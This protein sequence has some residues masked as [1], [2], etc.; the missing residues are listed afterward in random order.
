MKKNLHNHFAN[1]AVF[2]AHIVALISLIVSQ[3]FGTIRPVSALS[4][5]GWGG[6]NDQTT[7][8]TTPL[9]V[10]RDIT[11]VQAVSNP[12]I[13]ARANDDYVEGWDWQAGS[14]VTIEISR[15]GENISHTATVGTA[16]WD[17]S[18]PY[19]EYDFAGEFDIQTGDLITVTSGTVTRA[20]TVTNLAF[21]NID[22]D[23][24][25]VTGIASAGARVEIW[26]CKNSDCNW[27]RHVTA[28]DTS[29]AW[30]VDF[31]NVGTEP[32]EQTT[33]D[34]SP[35]IW[36]DSGEYDVNGNGT[37]YGVAI[38]NPR[39]DAWFEDGVIDAYDWDIGTQLTL[40]IEDPGTG[41]SPDYSTTT[42]VAIAPQDPN[43]TLGKF[44]LNGA[45][46]I[47]PGMIITVSG[48][49]AT[50]QLVVS[51]LSVTSV[52]L[53]NDTISGST[54]PNQD[55]WMWYES[56][57]CRGFRAND[58]GVWT[59]DYSVEGADGE[60][61]ADV[62]PG[63]SGFIN[64]TDNDGDN[65]SL[66]WNVVDQRFTLLTVSKTGTGSGTVISGPT[67]ITC[68][69]DCSESYIYNTSVTLTATPDT[70]STFTGWS[71]ACTGTGSCVV[72]I[73]AVKSVTAAFAIDSYTLTASKD[74]TGSGTVTSSPAGIICG[75]DCS[76][77]YIYDTSV[78]LT[79]TPDTGSAFTGWSGVCT[80]TGAC[81]IAMTAAK[82]VTATFAIDTYA[83]TASKD[84]TGSGT[85]TSSPVGITCGADCSENY[86][87]NTSVTLTATPAAGSTFTGWSGA[88]TGTGAC[89]VSMTA[90]K[91][92]TA[93][94]TINTYALTIS[95]DGT[96]NGMVTSSPAG[97]I[98]GADCSESYIYNTSV[99]LTATP[100]TGSTFTGWSGACTG[101]G[102]CVITMAA[103][104]SVT[105]TFTINTY[106]LTVSKTGAGSG[107]VT[108]GPAGITCGADCSENYV[109][110]T[111]VT[112]T[113]TPATGSA[114]TGWSGACTGTGA[115]VVSMTA[116][117]SVTATFAIT[118]SLTVGK[119]GDGSG[120][121]TSSPAGITCGTDCSE[122]Y[123]YNTS[124]TLTA[125]P[126]TGSTF[127]GWGGACTG[128]GACVVTMTAAKSVTATFTKTYLLTASKAGT[129]SGTVTSSPAGIAC[130]TDCSQ[131]YNYNTPV[132]LTA[133][134]ATGSTFTG[135]SGACTGTGSCV[136]TMTT[137]KSVTAAF[138]LKTYIL[139]VSKAGI[140]S[141]TVT[142]SPVGITC[143]TDCSQSYNYNIKVTLTATPATG[144][145][146]SGWS[147]ACTGTGACVVTMTAAKSVIATYTKT[148]LLTV[149]KAGTGGGTVTSTPI[150][151][152]CGTDCSQNYNYNTTVTL[153]AKPAT[154]STFSGWS[155]AC[156]GTGSCVV[157][158]MA[159]K[160][161]TATFT[162]KTYAL[163]VTKAGSGTVTSSPVGITCGVDCSQNYNYNTKVTLTARPA[164]GFR[165][166]GWS[167]ACT[168]TGTCVVTMTAAK[169]AKAT[170]T[171]P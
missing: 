146:F 86:A 111:S 64:A 164:T 162:I 93:T 74:G 69:A 42:T 155:G 30:T 56:S 88:C 81:I 105:A 72:P 35:G 27:S 78:T 150:G 9:I 103:V 102:S 26:V 92:V 34:I 80:G 145:A 119:A 171:S 116:A 23:T 100:D 107:T 60:P 85:V 58:S 126:A 141:G 156:T 98:C 89:V 121:V 73:T 24:D 134:P 53:V 14:T 22:L 94:F 132:T 101:T 63:S 10:D 79:A 68:G 149:S 138:K 67:G 36:I 153:T 110:N 54:E 51:D 91:S 97:I 131:Y 152:T 29:G 38:P 161:V 90:A 16:P 167:G 2:C 113:A 43:Q 109:Y 3:L 62:G 55:M 129:G 5:H 163:T 49:S 95:K 84:G 6:E 108:S 8:N 32:D 33:V 135:W 65:T 137:A 157:T 76:E 4:D 139:T 147:G 44:I 117:K 61:I 142:S 1:N 31:G 143:G 166:T 122:N 75:A 148:Y 99:T 37:M 50:K 168:G 48:A 83:L 25:I 154:G 46:V 165:F 20:I 106:A 104:K 47:T 125:T 169:S 41:L 11:I 130:G 52:D 159:A 70:G 39:F 123:I 40:E 28:N 128:T 59:V 15:T 66:N 19:F 127:S 151:I 144:S 7:G 18:R 133:T 87:Y 57:C 160:F 45:F 21:T 120:T 158:I 82:S 96:G 114:F 124:I 140:G 12:S 118:H 71:G 13:Q 115:C 170:F 112:L 136:V 17:P 77:S